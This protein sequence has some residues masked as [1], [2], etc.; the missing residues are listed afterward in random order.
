MLITGPK[1]NQRAVAQ[2]A[3]VDEYERVLLNI[4]VK[5]KEKVYR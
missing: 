3:I 1:H 5:P 4:Y 2:I